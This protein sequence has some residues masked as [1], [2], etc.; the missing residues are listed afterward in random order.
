M[1]YRRQGIGG[2]GQRVVTKY[3][4]VT[5]I[6]VL[7]SNL[8]Y[9]ESDWRKYGWQIYENAGDA[10]SI[11]L[12]NAAIADDRGISVLWNPAISTY[13]NY[14]NFTYGHQSRF[15]GIIQSDLI[16]FPFNIKNDRTFNVLL[17]H[18]SV[19]KI[20]NT[21]NLL[22]DWGLD[23]TPN[24]GDIGENNGYL[25]EGE[26]L[27]N[28]DIYYFN[29]HQVGLALSTQFLLYGFDFGIAVKGL[30]HLLGDRLGS[31]IGLDVGM[32]KSF[33]DNSNIGLSIHNL[34]PGMI[35]WDSG[36][37]ELSKPLILAGI[38]QTVSLSKIPIELI[39]LTDVIFN[40]SDQSISDDFHLGSTGGNWRVGVEISY[41]KK[42]SVRLGR[43]QYGFY[44]TGLGISWT[45]FELNYAYQLNSKSIDLGTN[46]V[47]SFTLNPKWF[48][49]KLKQ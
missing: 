20:P 16:S 11:A 8:L 44:S 31:G 1:G 49:N 32:T 35:V 43:N 30:F 29:Q 47:I 4:V 40:V 45:N 3:F 13:E 22:L 46:H 15:A 37:T 27:D 6:I 9:A 28:E 12:G 25:D 18:E 2:R 19:S 26:R 39:I 10:R 33:W 42:V 41:N 7:I 17:L 24:T 38:S 36:F 34:I 21:Q 14:R 5:L 23:G 48:V